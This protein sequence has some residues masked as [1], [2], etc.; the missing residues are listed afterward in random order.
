[1][2]VIKENKITLI[3]LGFLTI[4]TILAYFLIK[5]KPDD[6]SNF[7][8]YLKN[9][10]INE[11]IPINVDEEAIAK[12]YLAEYTKLIFK[13]TNEA[14]E[15]IEKEY[16]DIKFKDVNDFKEYFTSLVDDSFFDAEIKQINITNF[17]EYKQFYIVDSSNMTYVFREYSINDYK[18]LFDLFTV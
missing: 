3:I 13:N 9:Y 4:L 1:M 14:Y 8:E 2:E 7:V 18:V 10:K 12:K 15:L 11:L 17:G 16:R 5:D 6:E